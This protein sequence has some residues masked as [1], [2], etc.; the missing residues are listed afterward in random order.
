MIPY[1]SS[2]IFRGNY[3]LFDVVLI[4]VSIIETK[5]YR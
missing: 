2:E 3:H 5:S 4:K 1:S